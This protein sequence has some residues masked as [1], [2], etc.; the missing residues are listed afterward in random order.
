MSGRWGG[1]DE[2]GVRTSASAFSSSAS[3]PAGLVR[4]SPGAARAGGRP[5]G[6]AA[7][8]SAAAAAGGGALHLAPGARRS[9]LK[10]VQPVASCGG[11]GLGGGGGGEG[12]QVAP[13]GAQGLPHPA[14]IHPPRPAPPA[15]AREERGPPEMVRDAWTAAAPRRGEMASRA[16]RS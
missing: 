1:G 5:G 12:G 4:G 10:R 6:A 13:A 7:D 14:R 8:A 11:P 3:S 16:P 2:D 9:A 15:A